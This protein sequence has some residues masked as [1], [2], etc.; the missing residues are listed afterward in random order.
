MFVNGV[1][2]RNGSDYSVA[3]PVTLTTPCAE[4]AELEIVCDNA[5]D[6]FTATDQQVLFTPSSSE[7]SEDN[8]Q[9]YLNGVQLFEHID[10]TI[11]TP[12]VTLVDTRKAGVGDE[13]DV[14][15][16]RTS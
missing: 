3:A 4:G 2:L 1:K 8:M 11:G 7:I 15:I 6:Q 14:C 9:V 13:V 16:R 5:E 10:Y 12:S